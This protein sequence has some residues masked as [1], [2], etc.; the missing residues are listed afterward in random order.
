MTL[1][2][3]MVAGLIV[4]VSLITL[5]MTMVQGLSAMI[6]VEEQLIA[7]QKAREVLES[8]FTARSTQNLAFTDIESLSNGGIFLEG[9]QPIRGMGVDGIANTG[10]D[11]ATPVESIPL[12]GS[13]GTWG[14]ADDETRVLDTFQRRISFSP[15]LL[16]SSTV[17]QEIRN[18]TIDVRFLSRGTWWTVSVSS[19]ISRFA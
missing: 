8:V 5:A 6:I 17:D 4:S 15:V 9:W 7:K 3:V 10:D 14:T 2:E 19:Y 18:V 11:A 16:P 13:D 1:L 12:P